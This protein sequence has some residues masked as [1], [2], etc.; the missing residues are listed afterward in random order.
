MRRAANAGNAEKAEELASRL[1]NYAIPS[2]VDYYLIKSHIKY[3]SQSEIDSFRARYPGTAIADRLLND[4]L[5]ELGKNGNWDEFNRQYPQFFLKDDTQLKCYDLTYKSM[6]GLNVANEAREILTDPTKY[7]EGCPRLI[8]A[9]RNSGQ[10][11]DEDVW[12][13]IR[14]AAEVNRLRTAENIAIQSGINAPVSRALSKPSSILSGEPD[15]GRTA[16]ELTILAIGRVA[17][18][19]HKEAASYIRRYVSGRFT[20]QEESNAWA[21]V[22][23]PASLVFAPESVD[24]WNRARY[25]TLSND[26]HEWKART[27]LRMGYWKSLRQT[28]E[29]MPAQLRETPTW[30]Y[31]RARA[32]S[33]EGDDQKA[34]ALY[35]SIADQFNF[36]GQLS[37]EELGEKITIPPRANPPSY[38]EV[39]AMSHNAGFARAFKFYDLGLHFEGNREWNWELRKMSSDNELLAAAEYARHSNVLDRMVNTSDRTKTQF[40]FLQR[41]PSPYIDLMRESTSELGLEMAWV[42]GLIRQESRFVRLARSSAGAAGL[43]QV[44]PKTAKWVAKKIGMDD[45]RPGDVNDPRTNIKLGTSYLDM[46]YRDLDNSQVL[47]SAGYN[48]GPKRPSLWR[49]RLHRSVEGAVFAE[50][51]P[52]NETR[53]YVK[54]VMSNATYYAALY[55]NRP[56]SLKARMGTIHPTGNR[57]TNLP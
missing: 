15:S 24:Y 36:Y 2:Y 35:Q 10:F 14:L 37:R 38:D 51:I 30:I 52:F 18:K 22:A 44:M 27:A 21:Q 40:D 16:H 20:T 13:Q 47:A 25:A 17:R 50:I 7:G 48:A 26:A 53:T 6:R 4:W 12:A 28:I 55:S 42:Y 3:A 34:D 31:W 29:A 43:M 41:F 1:G 32:L 11:N 9:L 39:S 19:D 23:L 5:L 54:N 8:G 57:S 33:Y 45:F 49:S 56:Q 46:V